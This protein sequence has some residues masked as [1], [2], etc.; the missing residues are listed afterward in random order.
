MPPR[1]QSIWRYENVIRYM[2]NQL[3]GSFSKKMFQQCTRL[4][5]DTFCALIRVVGLSFE[6]K[7]T[8]MRK[9]PY[10]SYSSNGFCKIG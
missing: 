4:N 8:N 2:K 10:G 5:F 3:F 9:D 7:N 6:Q 1:V